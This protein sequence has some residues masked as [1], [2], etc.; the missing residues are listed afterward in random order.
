M[1]P[2]SDSES[3]LEAISKLLDDAPPEEYDP[4]NPGIQ[5]PAAVIRPPPTTSGKLPRV[6]T[7][8]QR[9][10][11]DQAKKY[12]WLMTPPPPLPRRRPA[13]TPP[14]EPKRPTLQPARPMGPEPPPAI[15]V[16]VAPGRIIDVPYFAAHVSRKYKA[17]YG[18][19][20]YIIRFNHTGRVRSC[21]QLPGASNF[22]QI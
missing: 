10:D 13:P 7:V 3:I 22:R 9:S 17:R 11:A 2:E 1:E 6:G 18:N 15:P 8:V 21:R 19:E 4:T 14:P 5:P 12:A 16:E 20:R